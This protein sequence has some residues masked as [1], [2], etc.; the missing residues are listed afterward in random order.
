MEMARL[1]VAETAEVARFAMEATG[2]DRLGLAGNCGGARTSLQV[3]VH[4][5]PCDALALI[6]LRMM[7]DA[8]RP[9]AAMRGVRTAASRLPG[10]L[11]GIAR[12]VYRRRKGSSQ[13]RD[14]LAT[15]LTDAAGRADILILEPDS[16]LAGPIPMVVRDVARKK[17]SHRVVL[18]D[19]GA[20]S[21]QE[22]ETREQQV[23]LIARV[24]DWFDGCFPGSQERAV[25][26]STVEGESP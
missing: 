6:T 1:P 19:L 13:R 20:K 22:I 10:P 17:P 21:L 8:P 14:A 23:D 12:M 16:A 18:E 3:A 4:H 2:T 5:L 25:L 26:A 15:S 7:T 24:T 11:E 9:S